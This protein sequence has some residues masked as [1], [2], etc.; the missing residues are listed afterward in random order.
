LTGNTYFII[1]NL[2][3]VCNRS[4]YLDSEFYT[5]QF[6]SDSQIL[7]K[8]GFCKNGVYHPQEI[9]KFREKFNDDYDNKMKKISVMIDNKL[10]SLNF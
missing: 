8:I 2:E 4:G 9:A 5:Q 6:K 7:P 3:R 1:R 10:F